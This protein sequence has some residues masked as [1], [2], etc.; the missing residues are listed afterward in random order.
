MRTSWER[1]T[2]YSL[3][4]RVSQPTE[5]STLGRRNA[6]GRVVRYESD[7]QPSHFVPS[8]GKARFP[9]PAKSAWPTTALTAGISPKFLQ[10]TG[11]AFHAL[12]ANIR[13]IVLNLPV[14][15]AIFFV[16]AQA[17]AYKAPRLKGTTH[18]DL[19][20]LWQAVNEGN[21]DVQAH[22]AQQGPPNSLHCWPCLRAPALWR[23]TNCLNTNRAN[24]TGEH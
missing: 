14:L 8:T 19:N 17:A 4:R 2:N 6:S 1:V 18:P 16:A 20:G 24:L 22:A 11:A 23:A 9:V 21:W 3:A 15:I 5:R 13:A 7:G 12:R 10:L